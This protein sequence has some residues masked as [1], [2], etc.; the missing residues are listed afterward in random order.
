MFS[1]EVFFYKYYGAPHLLC[2]C[3]LFFTNIAVFWTFQIGFLQTFRLAIL[4]LGRGDRVRTMW[5]RYEGTRGW[6]GVRVFCW[7]FGLFDLFDLVIDWLDDWMI[8]WEDRFYF[9]L[10]FLL[11]SNLWLLTS[12][13]LL[14]TFDL[15][16]FFH[17]SF[18]TS[19][20]CL[21]DLW[22]TLNNFEQLW[23]INN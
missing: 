2:F 16:T 10:H 20:F 13:F 4:V 15:L 18:F 19:S 9:S 11:T 12:A 22:T 7:C 8:G 17:F 21:G 1:I 6:L 14:L 5:R 23:T 3:S